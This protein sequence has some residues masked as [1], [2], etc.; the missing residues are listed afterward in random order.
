M[1]RRATSATIVDTLPEGTAVLAWPGS[2]DVPPL[3]TTT[4]GEPWTLPA[5]DRVV[6]VD[7]Y[8]GGIALTHVDVLPDDERV[9]QARAT[10]RLEMLVEVRQAVRE[11][12]TQAGA[13]RRWHWGERMVFIATELGRVL[14]DL[15][16]DLEGP[17]GEGS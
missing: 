5:G 16:H 9:A 1:T 12:L 4:R 10:G 11:V 17:T 2:R 8:A 7:G 6:M 15:G 13:R 14:R 3:V